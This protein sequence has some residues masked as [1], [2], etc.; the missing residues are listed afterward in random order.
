MKKNT[1]NGMNYTL[2]L[3]MFNLAPEMQ[4][5]QLNLVNFHFSPL[6]LFW[7]PCLGWVNIPL[8]NKKLC[9]IAEYHI[10]I[11][12]LLLVIETHNYNTGSTF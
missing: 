2:N 4:F 5:L 8:L 6:K 9:L 10:A 7:E 12:Y 3:G 1:V 11:F